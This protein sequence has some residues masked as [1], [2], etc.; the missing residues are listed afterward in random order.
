MPRALHV[1]GWLMRQPVCQGTD[2]VLQG[3]DGPVGDEG[4]HVP[5]VRASLAFP[6][7]AE[8]KE[9][10]PFAHVHDAGLGP[11]A[12]L[13]RVSRSGVLC[14]RTDETKHRPASR[15]LATALPDS[16]VGMTR[17]K[18]FIAAP[19]RGGRGVTV[20]VARTREGIPLKKRLFRFAAPVALAGALVG[21]SVVMAGPAHADPAGGPVS[22]QA[23][24]TEGY[25]TRNYGQCVQVL[26]SQGY[27]LTWPRQLGCAAGAAGTSSA[28]ALCTSMLISADV[29]FWVAPT[30]CL[31]ASAPA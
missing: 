5:L 29:A 1:P 23:V 15:R 20:E 28:V 16:G 25:E 9:V 13:A 4:I 27:D 6:L 19:Q 18:K 14:C 26:E 30:A 2:L 10:E 24:S 8:P 21:G 31:L 3:P 12:V 17:T 11:E 22:T 7:E